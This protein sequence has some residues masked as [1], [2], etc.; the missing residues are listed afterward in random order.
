MLVCQ[1]I[2]T[3]V[4]PRR[5]WSRAFAIKS[6]VSASPGPPQR[7]AAVA[8][9]G[10]QGGRPPS[11]AEESTPPRKRHRCSARSQGRH[12][13]ANAMISSIPESS[14]S[15]GS[16]ISGRT[17][18]PSSPNQRL[19]YASMTSVIVQASVRCASTLS[20]HAGTPAPMLIRNECSGA[21][22]RLRIS[23]SI[24]CCNS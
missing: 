24:F 20:G 4:C 5:S 9:G 2:S 16:G 22:D 19:R 12:A 14:A 1:L 21:S 10:P 7:R 11:D 13:I 18:I 6:S 8:S 15:T 17:T 3:N 23:E